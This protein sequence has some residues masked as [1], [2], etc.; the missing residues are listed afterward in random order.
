MNINFFDDNSPTIAAKIK[1]ALETIPGLAGNVDVG[2]AVMLGR[3]ESALI[4]SSYAG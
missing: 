1:A 2:L 3:R 4:N